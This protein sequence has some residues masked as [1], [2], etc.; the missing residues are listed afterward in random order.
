ME[1]LG[2]DIHGVLDL[3]PEF[4][5]ADAKRVIEA[6]GEVH[7]ITGIPMSDEVLQ[8]LLKYNNGWRF[9]THYYSIVDHLVKFD[10]PRHKDE[11]G[12]IWADKDED[13]D[14]IKGWYCKEHGITRMYDDTIQYR[15]YM[16]EFTQFFL[17]SHNPVEHEAKLRGKHL[18]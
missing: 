3:N 1:R 7:I 17:Y 4:F 6:G 15:A 8:D 10:I 16:P 12:R 14:P 11:K 9:W 13:W 5:V 18:K 2:L